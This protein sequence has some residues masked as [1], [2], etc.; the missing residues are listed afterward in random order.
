M[1]ESK[2][3]PIEINRDDACILPVE[4]HPHK[5]AR[6][7]TSHARN[8]GKESVYTQFNLTCP[9]LAPR[10]AWIASPSSERCRDEK[11]GERGDKELAR[12][13][14]NSSAVALVCSCHNSDVMAPHRR[15]KNHFDHEPR[16]R[17]T[18]SGFCVASSSVAGVFLETGPGSTGRKNELSS[19][20]F[21]CNRGR[22]HR[23][24]RLNIQSLVFGMK[25]NNTPERWTRGAPFVLTHLVELVH[26]CVHAQ[27]GEQVLRPGAEPAGKR[28]QKQ[29]KKQKS[30][31]AHTYMGTHAQARTKD[32]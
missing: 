15:A 30:T 7:S 5:C 23:N 26:G 13:A 6:T 29:K 4:K 32:D 3:T 28:Q 1:G 20:R 31:H 27:S 22:S 14:E 12:W 24:Y 2:R 17:H 8:T 11:F 9:V 10:I 19:P 16:E 18:L 25:L 21:D